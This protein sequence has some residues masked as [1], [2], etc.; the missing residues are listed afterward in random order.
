VTLSPL[1]AHSNFYGPLDGTCYTLRT[2]SAPRRGS[3]ISRGPPRARTPNRDARSRTVF[4][5]FG[6]RYVT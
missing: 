3:R 6:R 2:L 4:G 5:A 1:P